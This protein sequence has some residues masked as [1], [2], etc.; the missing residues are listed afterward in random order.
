MTA[1][2]FLF[3][4]G[5][6]FGSFFFAL[7]LRTLS[8]REIRP[9][10]F[11]TPSH[12]DECGARIKP[13]HLVPVIG[14]FAVRGKCANCGRPISPVHP[15]SEFLSGFLLCAVVYAQGLSSVSIL[16]YFALECI[17]TAA[18]VDFLTMKIPDSLSL[19]AFLSAVYPVLHYG[20]W[21]GALIGCAISGGFLLVIALIFPGGF[22]GGDIKLAAASGFLLGTELSVVS[23]EF[24]LIIG[25]VFGAV[26][27]AVSRRGLRIKIPFGPFIAAGAVISYFFGRKILAVYY[28]VSF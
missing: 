21:K 19:L 16:E 10:V 23:M 20:D 1:Y 15:V 26:Y 9:S 3:V 2:I 22:G 8:F 18:E 17:I 4:I 5:L 12:C 25:S 13:L 24:A 6:C 28:S 27:A 14:Y 7:G 11:V